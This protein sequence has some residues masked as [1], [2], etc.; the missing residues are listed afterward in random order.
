M[1]QKNIKEL[2][3]LTDRNQF[4]VSART[5][6]DRT[7]LSLIECGHVVATPE[8]QAT[9]EKVLL[10]EIDRRAQEFRAVVS[11]ASLVD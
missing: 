5:G 8:E 3:A 11:G 2:R 1:H 10:A 7:R 4:W 9:L 6:I